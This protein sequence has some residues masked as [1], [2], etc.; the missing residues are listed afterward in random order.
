MKWVPVM[1]SLSATALLSLSIAGCSRSADSKNFTPPPFHVNLEGYSI[2]IADLSKATMMHGDGRVTI[3]DSE[4]RTILAT[5]RAMLPVRVKD[6]GRIRQGSS[7]VVDAHGKVTLTPEPNA[8]PAPASPP[9][10]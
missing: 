3:I 6:Y 10:P 7:I 4:G 2:E 1:V 8:A 9:Q 5:Q